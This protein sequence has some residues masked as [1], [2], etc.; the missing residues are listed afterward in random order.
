LPRSYPQNPHNGRRAGGSGDQLVRPQKKRPVEVPF[1]PQKSVLF[2]KH[3][4][5]SKQH[6]VLQQV[7]KNRVVRSSNKKNEHPHIVC[8]LVRQEGERLIYNAIKNDYNK[9]NPLV[10]DVGGSFR[11]HYR[12]DVHSCEH[13][14]SPRVKVKLEDWRRAYPQ[15]TI[16]ATRDG[17]FQGWTFCGCSA[18]SCN[19]VDNVTGAMFIHSIYYNTPEQIAQILCRT[20]LKRGYSLQHVFDENVGF[21]YHIGDGVYEG[22]YIVDDSDV[23]DVDPSVTMR[24]RGNEPHTYRHS[25]CRWMHNKECCRVE[26][27]GCDHV[28]AWKLAPFQVDA[29]GKTLIFQFDLVQTDDV[30]PEVPNWDEQVLANEDDLPIADA[31]IKKRAILRYSGRHFV[32]F[33]YKSQKYAI[34]RSLLAEGVRHMI[35]HSLKRDD[36]MSLL[37]HLKKHCSRPEYKS[38][39]NYLQILLNI[40][41]LATVILDKVMDAHS[42]TKKYFS[43]GKRAKINRHNELLQWDFYKMNKVKIFFVLACVLLVAVAT[44]LTVGSYWIDTYLFVAMI[45]MTGLIIPGSTFGI[46][47]VVTQVNCLQ[48][49]YPVL[50]IIPVSIIVVLILC[51]FLLSLLVFKSK[52]GKYEQW[53]SFKRS[54]EIDRRTRRAQGPIPP[55]AYITDF[56]SLY[57]VDQFKIAPGNSFKVIPHRKTVRL[58]RNPGVYNTGPVFDETAPEVFSTSAHNAKHAILG[59]TIREPPVKPTKGYW[60]WAAGFWQHDIYPTVYGPRSR[61]ETFE[62]DQVYNQP[63]VTWRYYLNRFPPKKRN[64]I[65]KAKERVLGGY[66]ALRHFVV[67]AFVKREKL[68]KITPREYEPSIPRNIQGVVEETKPTT[69]P[70]FLSYSYSLKFC[71]NPTTPWWYCSGYNANTFNWWLRYHLDRLGTVFFLGTDFSK[72]DLCQGAEIIEDEIEWYR[73]LRLHEEDYGPEILFSKVKITGYSTGC[74][75]VLWFTRR[76]GDNDTSSGNTRVTIIAV[77]SFLEGVLGLTPDQYAIAALGDDN[78]ALIQVGAVDPDTVVP[79]LAEHME[80]LGFKVKVVCS[81]EVI[82]AEFLSR[83]FYPVGEHHAVGRKPGR[84]LAK[85]GW[86]LA[87]EPKDEETRRGEFKGTLL[88]LLG[89]SNHVPFLRKYVHACLE[90]LTTVKAIFDRGEEMILEGAMHKATRETW[91][92]FEAL[93]G[94]TERDE[95]VFEAQLRECLGDYGLHCIIHSEHV[96]QMIKIDSLM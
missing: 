70:W 94:L 38:M 21:I 24:V 61:T 40:P 34:P 39:G 86:S 81:N 10:L 96:A 68:N 37:T 75:Y 52:K 29:T 64:L 14:N 69:G 60:A 43:L 25:A 82:E 72:Y 1:K 13:G 71:M 91:E 80:K 3:Y 19:H 74:K 79:L 42:W 59:R 84:V 15:S 31:F 51:L 54:V 23:T 33:I 77:K 27:N 17:N 12:P 9:P 88:S 28:L 92:S 83:R 6:K 22:T 76:S 63:I 45:V 95:A 85:L 89:E 18:A 5:N 49:Q 30:P 66:V 50:A 55:G 57:D 8:K 48:P 53:Y 65:L 87:R 46:L 11:N 90:R 62:A 93:Y 47:A 4:I 16:S 44:G 20:S 2:S 7:F 26:V 32:Y 35:D 67:K 73:W 58:K 36:Y 56:E 41:P 78:L